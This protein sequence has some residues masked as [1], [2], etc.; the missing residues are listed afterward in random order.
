MKNTT[1]SL[2]QSLICTLLSR[3]R[4]VLASALVAGSASW[5][6]T[7]LTVTNLNPD[8]NAIAALANSS[9]EVS[10]S[11]GL[12]AGSVVSNT[13]SVMGSFSGRIAGS[14]GVAGNVISFD[15][16]NDFNVGEVVSVT[17]TT[18]LQSVA[19]NALDNPYT[20]QF[21]IGVPGG[22]GNFR[23]SGNSLGSYSSQGVSLGDVDGDGDLD[24]FVA[25]IGQ[26]DRVWLNNGSGT[27]SDSGQS[28]GSYDSYGVSLGDVDGD[29]D[30]DAFVATGS[31]PEVVWLNDGNGNF[32][33]SGNRLGN[34][35]CFGVDLGDLDGDGDLDAF[36]TGYG[37]GN[38][39]WLNDGS[40]N[41]SG[42]GQS[43]G[44]NSSYGVSLG[45]VDGDGDLDAFV[46]NNGQASRVWLND[47]SGNF[48]DS[49]QNL[50]NSW[51][52]GV[53]LGD[54]DG[55][56][57]LDA[58]A[59]VYGQGN[60]IWL[61]NGSGSFSDSGQNLG[62]YN[63]FA[64]NLG[65]V[66]GDGDLDAF[67]INGSQA[68]R[69]W[70]NNGSGTFTDSGQNL[71]SAKSRCAGLGDVDGDGDLDAFVA[72]YTQANRV[73]LNNS[74]PTDVN[75]SSGSVAENQ[76]IG[77]V[78]G[79]FSTTDAD[80]GDTPTYSLVAGTGSDDNGSFTINGDQLKTAASF[81]YETKTNYSIR[82]QT[83]DGH[84]GTYEEA[85]TVTITDVDEIPPTLTGF[86]RN[87]PATSPVNAD[88]LV[89]DIT[90][91]E[92]VTNVDAA[93]FTI[94]GTTATG[95]LAGSGTAYTLTVSGGDLS[96][97]NGTVGL[98]LNSE[99]NI[100]D[101]AGNALPAGEPSTDETYQLD[102]TVPTLTAFARNTPATNPTDADSL[103]FDITFDE[104]VV[105]VDASDFTITGTTATGVLA[106]SGTAYT[107]T[108]SGGDLAD[109]TGTAGLN[110]A[111][112][113]NI[114]DT[115]GN[116][117]PAGEPATDETY[118]LDNT[119]PTVTS[120]VRADA[121]PT[122]STSVVFTV[123]FSEPVS[124]IEPGDFALALTGSAS[125][126]IESVS[127][128]SGSSVTVTVN[129]VSPYGTLGLNFDPSAL[130][131]VLDA[132]GHPATADF[133]GETY[134]VTAHPV[135]TSHVPDNNAL[136]VATGS[137]VAVTF[138]VDMA[139]S[140]FDDGSTFNVNGS[141]SGKIQGMFSG[142]GTPTITYQ[143]TNGFR[144][145]ETVSVVLTTGLQSSLGA[146]PVAPYAFEFVVGAPS[147]SGL[148][149]A[150]TN[151]LGSSQSV[152]ANLG[153]LDGD[154]DLDA[155]VANAAQGNRVWL[156]DGHGSFADHGQALG[157]YNSYGA[158]LGDVDGDGDLDAFVA[159]YSQPNRVWLNDG[160][161]TFSD[162]G[163]SLGSSYSMTV[164]LGDLDGD[165]D[166]D[167]FVANQGQGNKVW[168][169]DGNGNFS[170]SG[171][172]LGSTYS[173]DVRLGDVD[174]DGDLDV[175]VANYNGEANRVWLNDGNGTFS[176]SGQA[177]GTSGSYAVS[178]GDLDGDGDLDAF[179]ANYSQPNRV[180][181]NNGSGSFTDSGQSLGGN[182]S[183]G[184]NLADVD[185]D[186]DLDAFV[187]NYGQANRIWL[188]DG[189]GSFSLSANSLGNSISY[190][191]GLGDLDDDGDIDAFVANYGQA[192]RVWLNNYSPTSLTLSTNSVA[193]NEATGTVV[194]TFSTADTDAN[195][196]HTYSLVAGTGSGGNASFT[197]DGDQLKTAASFDYETQT[198]YSI[199]VQ[200]DDGHSGT[201]QKVFTVSVTDVD[202]T[203]PTLI[204]ITRKTPSTNPTA[205]NTLVFDITFDEPVVYVDM[206]DFTITGTTATGVLAGSGTAYTITLSG[207]DLA[208]FDGTVGLDL[209]DGQYILDAAGN[210]LPDS[211]PATD[212]TYE[213]DNTP[214][215]L[216]A[217]ARNTPAESLT[218]ADTLVFD[219]TFNEP[220]KYVDPTDYTI[221]GTTATGIQS[222]SGASYTL[223][224]SGGDL[225][226][227]NGTVGLD[228]NAGAGITDLAGNVLQV[229]GE[230]ATDETYTLDN[231]APT[232]TSIVRADANP[233]WSTSVVFTVTF[234]E[235]VTDIETG[236]FA[237]ALTGSASGTI[238][239]VSS[240]S[241]SSVSV[242]VNGVS[243]G[244]T[245][246]LDFSHD[247]LDSVL[248][249]A[250]NPAATDF[251]GET[252]TVVAQPVV[253]AHVPDSNALGVATGS[254]IA[255]TFNM[256][257]AQSPFDD[258]ST[259]NVNGSLSGRFFGMFSG[260]GTPTITF[261]P[262]NGFKPGETVNVV[263]T[264][265]LYSSDGAPMPAPYAFQFR[266]GALGG[267]GSFADSGNSLGSAQS[268]DVSLG[269]LD[270]DGDLDAFVANFDQPS[271][272]WLN[273]GS[274]T[275]TSSSQSLGYAPSV[276]VCL[277]DLDS[278][279]DLDAFVAAFAQRNRIWLND[280]NGN[281]ADSG[282]D[283]GSYNSN[284]VSLGD[285]DGDGD[286]DAFVAN[287]AEPN[288]VWLNDGNGNFSDSGQSLGS[289]YSMTVSLGDVDGDGDLD[290]FEANHGAQANRVW[291]NDGNGNFADS[292]QS[293]GS[294]SSVDV[295]LGDV[296]GDGDLDAFVANNQA[297]RVW[298]N[299]GNGNF[300]DSG[301]TLGTSDSYNVKLGDLDGDGDLDAITANRDQANRVWLNDGSGSFSDNGQSL[302]SSE[303]RGVSLGDL[304][305]D[306]DIDAFVANYNQ[307]NRIWL[308]A[309]TPVDSDG[310]G[311]PDEWELRYFL[312]PT[313]A[314]AGADSDL[315]GQSNFEEYMAGMDPT[316]STSFF[317]T[318][319]SITNPAGFVVSWT[320][321]TG[322]TYSVYWNN[323]LTNGFPS[324]TV[325]NLVYPQ[326][327][328]TDTVH[329]AETKSFYRIGVQLS[330]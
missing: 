158:S 83:A 149:A 203:P 202:D 4:L 141:L 27:F 328:W 259:F 291:L 140:S 287:F 54:V 63:S 56:G 94:T 22:T 78:V 81:D 40:G 319:L 247:A 280:G 205:A 90:F 45:D 93:A 269:D 184:V 2:S 296:D 322:R 137:T 237:L 167:A 98:N 134:T 254:T 161:G 286:L 136:D 181:L 295:N 236:D 110:L 299:D 70:L 320:A 55:D 183:V 246:G 196:T 119:A 150:T 91:N 39:V 21:A 321:V 220:V 126:T 151:S 185:G 239:D 266:V 223:T 172:S 290:A 148:F 274:G 281:F 224:L 215:M 303:S 100:T 116:A 33:D 292:G 222:G 76:A 129:G 77:T 88:T 226:A 86:I 144:P 160:N 298:L 31:G 114:T 15:P 3:A 323:D 300:A 248:D 118:T 233:T 156:N 58:F 152:S 92:P 270:G 284:D 204:S 182:T 255:V 229:S 243:P 135:V 142:D 273:D 146:D 130:D 227:L 307:A 195:D 207:G 154:G 306:G 213:V 30:L 6:D 198:N 96:S 51:D 147:G 326:N 133:T 34:D 187:A 197:I 241:G 235:P 102:N 283:L 16:T 329:A 50:G 327:S 80:S 103:V 240:A 20:F 44:N 32:S 35:T 163:Q 250:G 164:R 278:D 106:G 190:G 301:N 41:F 7:I 234:S 42:N 71:G 174:G 218:A 194:G 23:D 25:N 302:G 82:V 276:G 170:D 175:F 10:F 260:D 325:S 37:I 289:S 18:N 120:I 231:T 125:G 64:V 28:L 60:Q 244:G 253:T 145:G 211:E 192:N 85:F 304:D 11:E 173:Q 312:D 128:A 177:L 8:A 72:N 105:N 265:D 282:Q 26:G 14:Y 305:G 293:L 272:V 111:A 65:D 261:H 191:A 285:V 294:S 113:Q 12:E 107:L 171:Q 330:E 46:S 279:G 97:L 117:L 48:S 19:T 57:D 315:D 74:L 75:L 123:M 162:S 314:V 257:M 131:S 5:A 153:D 104:P 316:N 108:V 112:G 59:A 166:L 201:Y 297:N 168:L 256:N 258:D 62:S 193:E 24:A 138:N 68:N 121:D 308:N 155:F 209:T 132:L 101:L 242:T 95:V 200:T 169:N 262:Y 176:D 29:G 252:Y 143:P 159:N 66:D 216:I 186:G 230:P 84:G 310:D 263:L 79:T 127:A 214:P 221:T 115:V 157:T 206:E 17:L 275:F 99:Q 188:N 43:L 245:L 69:A 199:R 73:W 122:W 271:R 228:L 47:G 87:T 277:G 109:L 264:K 217:F 165:G 311:L 61:N 232:V 53:S 267:S 288:R 49:G 317:A 251:T 89:F 219:I 309:D 324:A 268:Q 212:E 180:W 208:D 313:N 124:D 38:R 13:I 139:Q 9:I 249:A 1:R 189:S 52:Y 238:D 179:V 178:L 67:V 225:A 318:S 210:P 36:A